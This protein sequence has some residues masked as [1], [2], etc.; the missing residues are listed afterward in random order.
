MRAPELPPGSTVS[1]TLHGIPAELY[2]RLLLEAGAAGRGLREEVL[3]RLRCSPRPGATRRAGDSLGAEP[4]LPL[5]P[6]GE[7]SGLMM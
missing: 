7:G 2:L 5:H 1:L 6:G 3:H 4:A